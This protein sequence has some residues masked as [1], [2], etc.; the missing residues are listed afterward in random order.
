MKVDTIITLDNGLEY[1]LL[2]RLELAGKVYFFAAGVTANDESTGEY[3]F[4]EE[5]S[6]DAK[7]MIKLVDD[8]TVVA[9]LSTI[10]TKEYLEAVESTVNE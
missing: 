4:V 2:E 6:R 7:T 9:K 1:A 3:I 10:M 8:E 5:F